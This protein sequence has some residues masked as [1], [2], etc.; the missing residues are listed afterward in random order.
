MTIR[1]GRKFDLPDYM[2]ENRAATFH[3]RWMRRVKKSSPAV[4]IEKSEQQRRK[5][6]SPKNQKKNIVWTLFFIDLISYSSKVENKL[7]SN[8]IFSMKK[9]EHRKKNKKNDFLP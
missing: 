7:R 5:T 6:I 8:G 3:Y 1:K 2:H 4:P 9:A